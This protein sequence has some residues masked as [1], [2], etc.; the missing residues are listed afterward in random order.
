MRRS[1]ALSAALAMSC[2][3]IEAAPAAADEPSTATL[4]ETLKRLTERV[5]EMERSRAEDR[6]RIA[7]LEEKLETDR[8]ADESDETSVVEEEAP[9]TLGGFATG[10]GSLLNPAITAFLDMGGSWSSDKDNKARN[11]FTLREAEVDFRAAVTPRAD[12][13]LVIAIGEEIED[14]FGDVEIDFEFELEEGYLDVH[15]LPWDLALRAGKFRS[16]FGRNNLLHTHDLPQVTRPL[17]V[18]AFLGPEGL[19]TV[20]A[21]LSWLVPNPWDQYIELAVQVVNADGGAES[22]ILEGPGA[23][24]PAVL[25]HLK[26]FQDVGDAGSLEL[27]TTFLYSRTSGGRDNGYTVG[28]DVTYLWRDPAAPDFRSLVFQGELFWTNSD[29]EDGSRDDYWGAYAF[30]QYQFAQNW[31]TGVRLDYTE[32]PNVTARRNSDSDWG[33]SSYLTWYLAEPLRL[34]VEYQHLE[35]DVVGRDDSEDAI[36]LNLTFYIGAHPPHPYWVNR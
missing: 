23:A 9:A 7:E 26:L 33:V 35:R 3:A 11:R 6:R 10:P 20:G 5:E 27:G 2:L 4:I 24:N 17:A 36:L 13:V 16:A 29:F 34:R 28:A 21:S 12:G 30:G 25:N 22:P 18:Q 14:P 19:A 1:L 8:Y 15:T 32:L 31:Y